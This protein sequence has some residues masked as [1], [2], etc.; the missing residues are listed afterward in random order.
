M[1]YSVKKFKYSHSISPINNYTNSFW[2]TI[3]YKIEEY[4]NHIFLY[5]NSNIKQKMEMCL[6][7]HTQ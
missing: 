6:L 7:F 2:K 5:E 1:F 4:F 3:Y